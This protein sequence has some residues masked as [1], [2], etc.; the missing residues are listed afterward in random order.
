MVIKITRTKP[1]LTANTTM[2]TLLSNIPPSPS[3]PKKIRMQAMVISLVIRYPRIE[4][5]NK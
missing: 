2:L 3:E 5:V 1:P 4:W